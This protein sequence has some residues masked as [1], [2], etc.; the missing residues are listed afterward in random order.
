MKKL[1]PFAKGAQSG[2]YYN[3]F[4]DVQERTQTP[5]ILLNDSAASLYL[6]CLK[7][8]LELC[9]CFDYEHDFPQHEY[10]SSVPLSSFLDALEFARRLTP[11]SAAYKLFFNPL[12]WHVS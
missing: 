4:S 1:K 2:N 5:T 12:K 6:S 10:V 9:L 11:I 8:F 7:I 3:Y